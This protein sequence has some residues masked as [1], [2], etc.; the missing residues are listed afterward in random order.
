LIGVAVFAYWAYSG[1]QDY[2]DNVD[3]K[4]ATAVAS[5]KQEEGKLKDA[6]FAE[7][8]KN[9]LKTYVGPSAYGSVTVQYPK[10]WS[11]Y[12]ADTDDTTPFVDGYFQPNVVPDISAQS[13]SFALRIQVVQNSYDSVLQTFQ[14]QLKQG[15]VTV[16]PYAL[17]KLPKTVGSRLSGAIAQDKQGDMV[18]L[19]LRDKTLKIWT[20]SASFKSDFDNII[21]KNLSFSP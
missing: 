9:P 11:A 6:Q 13:S 12:V 1:R 5:A 4:V 15:K 2:K 19:P 21:L 7:A 3:A 18:L 17:P 10:T 8:E 16:Q 20:E 14:A